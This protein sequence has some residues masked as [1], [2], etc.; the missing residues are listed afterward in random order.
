MLLPCTNKIIPGSMESMVL[1]HTVFI[2]GSVDAIVRLVGVPVGVGP[3]LLMG[4]H[5]PIGA[6]NGK[7][8]H[9]NPV[10]GIVIKEDFNQALFLRIIELSQMAAIRP[11]VLNT[12]NWM[13]Q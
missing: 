13:T 8:I 4:L 6:L 3:G 7:V 9:A 11:T 12:K 5:P 10:V 2:V 1:D